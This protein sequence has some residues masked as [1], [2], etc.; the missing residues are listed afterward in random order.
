M[1]MEPREP[2]TLVVHGGDGQRATGDP[3][4]PPLVQSAT[5]FGG[6]PGDGGELLYS[7]YGTNPNQV[8]VARKMASLE[9][10]ED[11]LAVAS[12]MAAITLTLLSL[13]RAGD[14]LI[15]S[16]HLYGAT[17]LFMEKELPRRGVEVTFVDPDNPRSWRSAF[18]RS[19]RA[20]YMEIPT[21]P[22]LRIFD[23]RPVGRLAE[24]KGVL[25]VVDA[26]FATPV[27]LRPLEVGAD[28]VVH[29][30]TKYLGGHSDLVAGVVCGPEPLIDEVRS[31]LKLYG[32]ALD[33]HAAWLLDR[34]LRTLSVRMERHDRNA[35]ELA[36][37]FQERPEVGRVVHPSLPD[38]PDHEL[39]RELFRST[40]GMLGVVLAGGG[41]AADAFVGELRLAAVAPSLGGVETL[42]SLPRLTSHRSM[43]RAE[44]E[45]LGIEEGF[46]RISVGLEGVSD[47]REDFARGLAAAGR[48]G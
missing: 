37:W 26:T 9:G 24:Q 29:S 1:P 41:P 10:A 25:L 17:R 8:R 15:A 23:P 22:T 21:N 47:L 28:V 27:N 31:L 19:T 33:P 40:G 6:A 34:G 48:A 2:D 14:H 32:P 44:R 43:S 35:T 36:R 4:V 16:S 46:V 20:L 38:H 12:G 5:F 42:V 11:G 18:R 45:R 39:A 3:V 7:R 13:M 30:A